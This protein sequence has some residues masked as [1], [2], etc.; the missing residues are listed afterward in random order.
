[1]GRAARKVLRASRS[2][3]PKAPFCDGR[4]RQGCPPPLG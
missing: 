1:L 2:D 3:P 4:H